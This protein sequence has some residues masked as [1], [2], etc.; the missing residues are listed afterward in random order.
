MG[1]LGRDNSRSYLGRSAS[2]PVSKHHRLK[3]GTTKVTWLVLTEGSRG[4]S[5]ELRIPIESGR[6]ERFT[7]KEEPSMT[8][9]RPKSKS[10]SI[11]FS[12]EALSDCFVTEP[13]RGQS[14][15][16]AM[17]KTALGSTT[18]NLMERVV[19]WGNMQK[20][21]K[22]VRANRGAPGPDGITIND[23][24]EYFY[25]H[26]PRIWR[27]LLDG[28]YQPRASRRKSIEKK[29]GGERLL[30]IPNVMERL[31]H[32]AISQILTPI[33]DPGFS[34]SSYGYRPKRS[35]SGAIKQIQR[36][37]RDGYRH[38]LDMDLSK[39]FDRCQHDMLLVRVARKV[40][41]KRL[42]KMI[43]RFLRAGVI[44][45]GQ[46]Q[47]THEG[48]M[49]GS[50]LSPLL[51]NILLDDFDKELEKRGLRFVRY[52]DDFLVFTRT[53]Q[54]AQRVFQSVENY[55]TRK[56]KLV[57]N[58]DKSRICSTNGVEFLSYQFHG[59]GGQ[60]RVSPKS[61]KK[62]KERSRELLNRNHGKSTSQRLN[63]LKEYLRG[64]I[65][66]FALEQRK[67]EF[68]TLD[69]W[70]RRRMRACIWKQ[71]R[72]PSTRVRKLKQLGV[73][74]DEAYSHGNSRKGPWRMA[75]SL[76]ISMAMTNKWLDNLGLFSLSK[77]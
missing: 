1:S 71:W 26:W 18:T 74:N 52:A 9:R 25:Q 4:R 27:Q 56:L 12:H 10:A 77:R 62:F 31:I 59:Y 2:V 20:A 43:G 8:S 69:K 53:A 51:S 70:L 7:D 65:G 3:G 47:P 42:L 6:T 41:D 49:Q 28:T 54:A 38:C 35:A 76:A 13:Q 17:E 37:I 15:V 23:F 34:E 16:A 60:I 66:Y 61:L 64:W 39:F 22:A 46:H 73:G 19:R 11:D 45:E 24:P 14:T 57:V 50:P 29:D 44:V 58:R 36:T 33:F 21:W 30:G 67:S 55:L 5:T 48:V 63:E 72:L 75:K 32:Q 40:D 68:D